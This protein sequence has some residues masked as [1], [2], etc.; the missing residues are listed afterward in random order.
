MWQRPGMKKMTSK[1]KN[2][3]SLGETIYQGIDI[4]IK[5]K[6]DRTNQTERKVSIFIQVRRGQ[7]L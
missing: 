4:S 2:R 6:I 5:Q 7:Y 3:E 1:K